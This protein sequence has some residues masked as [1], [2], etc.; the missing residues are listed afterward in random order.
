M[1]NLYKTL[2]RPQL[3]YCVQFWAPH[4]RK[5]VKAL[6]RVQKRFTGMVP[7]MR[8][9]SYVDRLEK[10]G[11][12][13]LEQRWLRD[14]ERRAPRMNSLILDGE[15][16]LQ[17]EGDEEA[18]FEKGFERP[19]LSSE[20][21]AE[22]GFFE[23]EI[24]DSD[25]DADCPT[26]TESLIAT[27]SV[28]D[29]TAQLVPSGGL[30]R[31]PRGTTFTISKSRPR[32]GP[33]FHYS[34]S[35]SPCSHA[36]TCPTR[37][38]QGTGCGT[39]HTS[40]GQRSPRTL[41][42]EVPDRA[43]GQGK[44]L[45]SSTIPFS[46]GTSPKPGLL[47]H[48]PGA[49]SVNSPMGLLIGF[50]PEK[51]LE[52]G[53]WPCA[54]VPTSV[55][56]SSQN[57]NF[58][59]APERNGICSVTPKT[60]GWMLETNEPRLEEDLYCEAGGCDPGSLDL[61]SDPSQKREERVGGIEECCGPQRSVPALSGNSVCQKSWPRDESG[62][63]P[64]GDAPHLDRAEMEV[65]GLKPMGDAPHLDRAEMEVAGL[66]P[67]G[68]APHL[69]RAEMEVVGLKPMGD[70]PLLDR[71]DAE[72]NTASSLGE[73]QTLREQ[74]AVKKRRKKRRRKQPPCP[75]DLFIRESIELAHSRIRREITALVLDELRRIYIEAYLENSQ[76]F[77]LLD[78]G[79]ALS[80]QGRERFMG[81][82]IVTMRDGA[83]LGL[84]PAEHV[85][86]S[87]YRPGVEF[88]C[89]QQLANNWFRVKDKTTGQL[90]L[91][92]KE[93]VLSDWRKGLRNFLRLQP[94]AV[95]LVPYAVICDRSG[96]I[97]Y[98]TEDRDVTGFGRPRGM[99][100][101]YRMIFKQCLRFLSF[102]WQHGLHPGDFNSNILYSGESIYFD[103]TSLT[104]GEDLYTFNKSLKAAFGLLFEAGYQD[105][106]FDSFLDMMWCSG[107]QGH[108]DSASR[109]PIPVYPGLSQ[110]PFGD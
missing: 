53:Q 1:M 33:S 50:V 89:V 60:E 101:D 19:S 49:G 93:T 6:E 64:M 44:S 56:E 38:I 97:L 20:E 67:M 68:D 98:L 5:D 26:G 59:V 81:K 82:L 13:S 18:F 22:S 2:V 78:S 14:G 37:S 91:L 85:S 73:E 3:E 107:E 23:G 10:L 74:D 32:T 63:K 42:E 61:Y 24:S 62:Q 7:G 94:E 21:T 109:R 43:S 88:R 100:L 17:V 11:L 70:A 48:S 41:P 76:F 84:T 86:I 31:L 71:A 104:G 36:G 45:G 54:K 80:S 105:L 106:S 83:K 102:C 8:D 16:R 57:E 9:F 52:G 90:M 28:I 46:L 39:P 12:F 4:F 34:L 108:T 35:C 27:E 96:S 69:D 72:D 99:G 55:M 25:R 77:D 92:K 110:D 75:S 79:L 66:K 103:P 51:T 47:K 15:A 95:V 65:A 40:T 30:R 29:L 87:Y 58:T